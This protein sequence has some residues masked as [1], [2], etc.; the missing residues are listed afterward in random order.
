MERENE[1]DFTSLTVTELSALLEKRTCSAAEITEA[2]L[3]RIDADG[4]TNAYITVTADRARAAAKAADERRKNGESVHPLCGIPYALKDNIVTAGIPTTCAAEMLRD[5]VP[6]Y[7]AT[8]YEKISGLGGVLLGKA[9]LD[10]FAM[11][12]STERSIIGATVNPLVSDAAYS[13]GGSSG[14]SAAAVAAGEAAWAIGSDTGG[15]ARQPAS[16]CGLVAMKPTYGRVSRYGLVEF[17]SSLD[18]VCPI[19]RT[20]R[21]NALCLTA[22]SGFDRRDMTSLAET[23]DFTAGLDDGVAD[24][25][26]GL[27]D[28]SAMAGCEPGTI[29]CLNRAARILESLGASVEP[30]T[31]PDPALAQEAYLVI[32]S[33]EASSNLARYDGL[34]YGRTADGASA[35][36][37][38][39]N[40]RSTGFGEEVRRRILTGTYALSTQYGGGYYQKIRAAEAAIIRAYDDVFTHFDAVL[41]PTAAGTA[42]R[43][44]SYDE[45]PTALYD[46]DRFVTA[47]NLTGCPALTLPSGG[48]GTLPYG[49]MLMGKHR[50][51]SLLYRAGIA[52]E[53]AL[54][55]RIAEEVR[56]G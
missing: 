51:E 27:I 29:D 16:F 48:N 35:S 38:T 8:V 19:T 22:M 54:A 36:E 37:I 15:S 5:F 17:A 6:G 56:H 13:A 42:F 53:D 18:T 21:D 33:A 1:M 26:I 20:V 47:A 49:M 9:N 52:L 46:S 10:E 12:S 44:G 34:T 28:P 4:R 14:G 3:R 40:A 7:S 39:K 55:D 32:A 43:L 24:L 11:G 30:I 25:R 50:S 45:D 31:L 23:E 41:L 2:M